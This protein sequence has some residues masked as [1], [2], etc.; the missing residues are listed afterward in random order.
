M[1]ALTSSGVRVVCVTA[2]RGDGGNG[3]DRSGTAEQ[4]AA[5]GQLRSTELTAALA[6]L[7]VTE[8]LW[9]DY[10][11]GGLPAVN[12]EVAI[13]RLSAV[14]DEVGAETVLTFGPDGFTGHPDHRTVAAWA[15]R[16]RRP[17]GPSDPAAAGRRGRGGRRHDQTDR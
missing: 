11:D 16:G 5:L 4:R 2:T 7:G 14:L 3:L 6:E 8:H 12:S 9:L 17:R 1:A 13:G 10:P 15:T